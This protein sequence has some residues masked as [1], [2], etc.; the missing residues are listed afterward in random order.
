MTTTTTEI[1]GEEGNALRALI[2]THIS[3]I[4]DLRLAC[5]SEDFVQAERLGIEFGDQLRLMEDLHWSDVQ[6]DTAVVKLTMPTEQLRRVFTHLRSVV[7]TL[8]AAEEREQ[9]ELIDEARRFGERAQRVAQACDRV[10]TTVGENGSQGRE[11]T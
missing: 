3:G 10:L 6:S 1:T 5:E 4:D 9:A 8:S 7:A 2:L 11:D